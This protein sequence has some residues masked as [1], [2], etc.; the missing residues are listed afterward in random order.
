MTSP[1]PTSQT[2]AHYDY[3]AVGHVTRDELPDGSQ[4]AGGTALYSGLQAA[5]LGLRALIVTQGRPEEIEALL[6]PWRGEIELR[7]AAAEHTT[8]L[9]T[10]GSGARR[11]QRLLAWG[12]EMVDP[13]IPD[14]SILHLAPVARELRRSGRGSAG[15]CQDCVITPQGLLR[16]WRGPEQDVYLDELD[17]ALL[18]SRFS[19]AVVSE[20]EL[21]YCTSLLTAARA[22]GACVAVTAGERPTRL[23]LTDGRTIDGPAPPIA[24]A[25]DDLGA[26]DV[27]AAAFFVALSEGR[28]AIAATRFA[29]AAAA[30]RVGGQGPEAIGA[31]EQIEALTP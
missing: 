27:F 22:R 30:I 21:A 13:A 26:G 15:E 19:A 5:R 28:D 31:R 10:C 11:A 20:Q 14:C 18:P 8:A 25:L 6:A 3:V 17:S 29:N 23:Q 24:R 1:T 12:G 16:D 7:I 2:A 4:R 9:R